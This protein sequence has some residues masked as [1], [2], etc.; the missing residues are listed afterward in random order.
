MALC[1]HK[2]FE[3][4]TS[5]CRNEAGWHLNQC[6]YKHPYCCHKNREDI[7]EAMSTWDDTYDESAS[8]YR[9]EGGE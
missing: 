9:K 2:C 5:G 3:L 4:A 7:E 1:E 8:R 6:R